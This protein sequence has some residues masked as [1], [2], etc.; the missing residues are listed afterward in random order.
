M[1]DRD[2]GGPAG[3][4]A[5]ARRSDRRALP[6]PVTLRRVGVPDQLGVAGDL[7]QQRSWGSA[8]AGRGG[9][10]RAEDGGD[11]RRD[12]SVVADLLEQDGIARVDPTRDALQVRRALRGSAAA[13]PCWSARGR[14]AGA[15]SRRRRR[16]A[17]PGRGSSRVPAG[18]RARQ[19]AVSDR[20]SGRGRATGEPVFV[21]LTILQSAGGT[22][23]AKSW[24]GCSVSLVIGRCRVV[25]APTR[26]RARARWRVLATPSH[27]RGMHG[28]H[29]TGFD[30]GDDAL[31]GDDD[32][33]AGGQG[34][35]VEARESRASIQSRRRP[36]GNRDG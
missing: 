35:S 14:P 5:A 4:E 7:R 6:D 32:F 19:R 21:G 28:D 13:P 36:S 22:P 31:D 12:R 8:G 20:G 25:P 33:D 15:R 24:P 18:C 34:G 10:R 29:V 9:H 17:R 27:S 26:S 23:P 11:Y 16:R 2:R 30:V 3:D 1:R